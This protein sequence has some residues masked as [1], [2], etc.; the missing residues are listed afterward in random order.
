MT[1]RPIVGTDYTTKD[2]KQASVHVW[3]VCQTHVVFRFIRSNRMRVVTHE[4]FNDNF[5][6]MVPSVKRTW[7]PPEKLTDEL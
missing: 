5:K 7:S 4:M 6:E 2:G 3:A 1:T